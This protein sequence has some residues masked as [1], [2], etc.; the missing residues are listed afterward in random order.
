M[1]A[2]ERDMLLLAPVVAVLQWMLSGGRFA[3]EAHFRTLV[4]SGSVVAVLEHIELLPLQLT[5]DTLPDLRRL[6][7][8]RRLKGAA[9]PSLRLFHGDRTRVPG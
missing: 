2:M 3:P 7:R 1:E 5:H 6:F 8:E 9:D 4:G